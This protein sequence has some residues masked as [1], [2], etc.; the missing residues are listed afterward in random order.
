MFI[1][2]TNA[3]SEHR[4]EKLIIRKDIIRSV[5]RTE[6][7]PEVEEEEGNVTTIYETVTVIFCGELGSW[8][9]DEGI[10]EIYEML[11]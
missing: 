6:I 1:K 9:V 7:R 5:H 10:D 4:G 2:V 11:K 8:Y 3:H